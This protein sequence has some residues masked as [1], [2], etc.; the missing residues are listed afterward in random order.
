MWGQDKPVVLERYGRRRSGFRLPPWLVLLVIGVAA[1]AGAVLFVQ[2]RY[3]PPRLSHAASTEL[4]AAFQK[5]DGERTRL[6][7][8][9]GRTG[10]QLATALADRKRLE[11]EL[12]ASRESV[13]RLRGDV[14]AAV[15]G[16]PPDPRGGAV[17]VRAA[18]LG[19][20]GAELVYEVVLSR[21]K[22]GKPASGVLQFVVTGESAKGGETSV[23]LKPVATALGAQE[24]LRGS[25]VMPDG[26]KPRQATINVLDRVDGQ[27]LGMRVMLV[28]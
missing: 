12:A 20:R 19:T 9:L 8:E 28:K 27:S 6:Q 2:E 10:T 1:G 3:L 16:L 23:R 24:V 22:P 15:A 13:E 17:E 4:Q 26:L 21:E 7:G 18:R 5:A 14:A 25:L 11:D